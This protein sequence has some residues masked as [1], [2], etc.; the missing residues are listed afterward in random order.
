MSTLPPWLDAPL[1]S[2]CRAHA[3]GHLGHALLLV[4]PPDMG[5]PAL[6]QALAQRLL[7][8]EAAAGEP[9]CGRCRACAAVAGGSH[10]DLHRVGLEVNERTDKLRSEITIEQIRRLCAWLALTTQQGGA[11][12]ALIERA[13]LLNRSAANALLKT[14]EDPA[15]NR[16][17]LLS[18]SRPQA[19][20]ATIRS[21]CQ[22]IVVRLPAPASALTWLRAQGHAE[23][24]ARSALL[25]TRGNPGGAAAWLA[26]GRFDL[27]QRI[28]Q[29]LRELAAGHADPHALAAQWSTDERL[30]D[31]L[32]FAAAHAAEALARRARSQALDPARSEALAA[33]Y[34]QAND[35][36]HLLSTTVRADLALIGLLADWR[37]VA[38]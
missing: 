12:V 29:Q 22:Q 26:D 37:R 5:G 16:F 19:L 38:G 3:D 17:L 4:A 24:I 30:D 33:W 36:R 32:A 31:H 21:R 15:A 13:D 9:A 8:A 35:I 25:A 11:Q 10:P 7:C 20:P 34:R 14:L 27:Y 18:S 6:A 2:A 1:R 28:G 23:D